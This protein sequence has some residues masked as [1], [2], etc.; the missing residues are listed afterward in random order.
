MSPLKT[1]NHF[2]KKYFRSFNSYCTQK[3]KESQSYVF[4]PKLCLTPFRTNRIF[5]IRLKKN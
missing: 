3:T 2:M 5:F 1:H 4:H